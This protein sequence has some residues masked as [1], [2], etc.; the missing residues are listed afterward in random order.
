MALTRVE[1]IAALSLIGEPNH[2]DLAWLIESTK[3]LPAKQKVT[4]LAA[5]VRVSVDRDDAEA[6]KILIGIIKD[7]G[8]QVISF[9]RPAEQA[10]G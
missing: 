10:A 4:A 3:N 1:Q 5:L 2:K 6:R 7:P 9:V 8:P